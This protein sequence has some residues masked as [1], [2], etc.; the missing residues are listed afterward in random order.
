MREERH[1]SLRDLAQIAGMDVNKVHRLETGA[2]KLDLDSM[3]RIAKALGLKASAL[4]LDED[5]ELRADAVGTAIFAE[6]SQLPADERPVVLDM[7]RN[8]VRIVRGSAAGQSAAALDGAPN[9]VAE[10]AETWN[11]YTPEDRDHALSIL[12]FRQR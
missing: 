2:V 11:A 5:V 8:L 6:L 7:A 4:L 12:R 9:Q 1:L 10:L 3:R